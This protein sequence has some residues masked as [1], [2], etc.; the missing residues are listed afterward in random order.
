M[1]L[2][3]HI[4]FKAELTKK[5]SIGGYRLAPGHFVNLPLCQLAVLS[6]HKNAAKVEG[7]N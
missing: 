5:D 2:N 1:T 4:H 6:T 7:V 3:W